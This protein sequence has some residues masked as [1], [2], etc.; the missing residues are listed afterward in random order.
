MGMDFKS[1]RKI[2]TKEIWKRGVG[3]IKMGGA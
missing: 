2:I 1:V 3:H